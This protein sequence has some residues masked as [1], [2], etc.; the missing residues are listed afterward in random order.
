MQDY[1]FFQK[2][3]NLIAIESENIDAAA[4]LIAQGFEKQFEEIG[5]TDE[6]TALIRLADIRKNNDID[7][8]NFL[9]GAGEMPWI[10]MLTAAATWLT[11]KK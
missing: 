3:T 1:R 9:A 11:Q 10:G 5:A 8:H 6:K 4:Q 7:R 2:G